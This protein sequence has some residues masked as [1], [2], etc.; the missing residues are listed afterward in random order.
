MLILSPFAHISEE[1]FEHIKIQFRNS[2]FLDDF[3]IK[4]LRKTLEFLAKYKMFENWRLAELSSVFF[5]IHE[6]VM[7][8]GQPVY[9]QGEEANEIFFVK[10]GEFEVIRR[11]LR[12]FLRFLKLLT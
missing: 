9:I 4:K 7:S 6:L 5:S 3:E 12:F 2:L 10:S 8:R 11:I 1:K